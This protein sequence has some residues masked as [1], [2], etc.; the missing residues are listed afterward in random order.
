VLLPLLSLAL[1]LATCISLMQIGLSP[2]LSKFVSSPYTVS[3][4]IAWLLS[5]AAIS[6]LLAQFVIVRP[7]RLSERGLLCSAAAVMVAG[8]LLMVFGSLPILYLGIA[9]TSF[10]SAMATP[11]YQ[12]LINQKLSI[13]KGAGFVATSHTLGYGF[14]A[15]LVPFITWLSGPHDL[16]VGS[17]LTAVIFLIV[18]L[19][20]LR[21]HPGKHAEHPTG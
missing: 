3:H 6:T 5:L 16:L 19:I 18:T 14:S 20:A 2:A 4:H 1:L 15:L 12:L 8:L 11:A 9:V 10:G 21:A 13:G 7:Q 17:F